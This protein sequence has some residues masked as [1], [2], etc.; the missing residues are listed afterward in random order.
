MIYI[1][2]SDFNRKKTFKQK[3]DK[4]IWFE[5]GQFSCTNLTKFKHQ[6]RERN[7]V[8]C[9]MC[10]LLNYHQFQKLFL[11]ILNSLKCNSIESYF[12]IFFLSFFHIFFAEEKKK[13]SEQL[14]MLKKLQ[15][16]LFI[17]RELSHFNPNW[18]FQRFKF[19]FN[20]VLKYLVD[21]FF[22]LSLIS[23]K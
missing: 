5:A 8:K 9:K 6:I 12:N 11:F 4:S 2:K 13:L 17:F 14:V 10:K 7:V 19:V 22:S 18:T 3:C 21:F 1:Y 23:Q 16:S 20:H 15:I